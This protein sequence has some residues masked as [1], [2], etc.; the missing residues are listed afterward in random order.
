[1]LK[2]FGIVVDL[3][4]CTGCL[5]CEIA[6]NQE[7]NLPPG[8]Q[9]IKVHT[10]GPEEIDKRLRTEFF[11]MMLDDCTVCSHRILKGLAPS[12]VDNCPLKALTFGTTDKILQLLEGKKRYQLIK[13]K[14]IDI[15]V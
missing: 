13:L 6:C 11:P 14:E 5:A 15:P 10:I 3:D 1:M 2:Q 9:W 12:C 7:N 4:R 8:K